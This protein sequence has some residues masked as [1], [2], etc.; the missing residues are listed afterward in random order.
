MK[1]P[2]RIA[3][4]VDGFNLYFGITKLVPGGAAKWLDIKKLV[5]NHLPTFHPWVDGEIVRIIYFT[6]EVTNEPQT[7]RRQQAY[8]EALRISGSVDFVEYGKFKSYK[9]ENFAVTGYYTRYDKV[10]M[11]SDPLPGETWVKL[12][13]DNFIRVG[14]LRNE[15]KGSD[16]NLAS[17]LLIDLLTDQLDAAILITNDADLGF[18]IKY[19]REKV[20]LGVINGRGTQTVSELKG[21]PDDGVGSNWWYSLTA[22]DLLAAQLPDD[23][24]GVTRPPEWR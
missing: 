2:K 19:A 9:D 22:K 8:I 7:L 3:V 10:T 5:A 23:V 1:N 15:E 11:E 16:V 6:S 12:D 14:H 4:Y 18:P 20:P 13:A 21:S 24:G 17:H